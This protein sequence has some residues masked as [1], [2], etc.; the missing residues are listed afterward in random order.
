MAA[1]ESLR[2]RIRQGIFDM[3]HVWLNEMKTLVKDEGV[4]IFFIIVPLLYPLLYSWAYNN[5]VVREVP[6][7]V[8]DDSHSSLS[9]EFIRLY[10]SSP[11]VKVARYCNNMEEAKTLIGHQEVST[12][13]AKAL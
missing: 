1:Q 2:Q 6:V 13:C 7:A 10:D 9:R 11:D 8:I 3:G 5:E 12:T 4:V